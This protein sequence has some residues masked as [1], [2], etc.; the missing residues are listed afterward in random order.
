MDATLLTI[1][2]CPTCKGNLSSFTESDTLVALQCSSC[3][4]LYPVYQD[5]PILLKEESISVHD[6]N[7]GC[8]Y[9]IT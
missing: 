3:S 9:Q 5:I 4:V 1:L 2:A 6:W 7:A 8:R